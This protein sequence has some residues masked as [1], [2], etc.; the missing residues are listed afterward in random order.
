MKQACEKTCYQRHV[1]ATCSCSD[2]YFPASGAA[3]NDVT[4]PVC[5]TSNITQ[6]WLKGQSR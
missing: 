5:S 2:A 3:F 4:V 6:G 1:I